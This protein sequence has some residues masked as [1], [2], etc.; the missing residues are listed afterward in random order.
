MKEGVTILVV[1]I[2]LAA[3]EDQRYAESVL[4]SLAEVDAVVTNLWHL[5]ATTTG[6]VER[7]IFQLEGCHCALTLLPRI[8]HFVVS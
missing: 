4:I 1:G 2:R 6:E 7:F 3:L 5:E 8:N